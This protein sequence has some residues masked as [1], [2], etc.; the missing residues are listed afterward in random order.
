MTAA[1]GPYASLDRFD[2]RKRVVA[3]LESRGLLVKVEDYALSLGKCSRCATPVEPLISTQWFVKTKPLAE[4]AHRSRG[5][6][7]HRDYSGQLEQDLLR[8]DV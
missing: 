5:I 4:K 7:A 8:V 2:A 1:A 3:D 6:Q